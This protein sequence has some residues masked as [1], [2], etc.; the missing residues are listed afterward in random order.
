VSAQLINHPPA[1]VLPNVFSFSFAWPQYV[2]Y[3]QQRHRQHS[4]GG[5]SMSDSAGV[6]E[7]QFINKVP[8]CC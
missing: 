7:D 8:N 5:A 3:A 4:Q 2:Q 6:T 1:G